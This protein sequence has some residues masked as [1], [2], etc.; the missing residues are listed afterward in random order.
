M[1]MTETR[2]EFADPTICGEDLRGNLKRA[3]S[4]A[5]DH[6]AGCADYHIVSTLK[7]ITGHM[8]FER[9][10][11]PALIDALR[12]I[13]GGMTTTD[14][15]F[16]VVVAACA[17]TGVLSTCAHAAWAAGEG[18][19]ARS[20]FTVLDRCRTPL[21]LCEEYASRNGLT[22]RTEVVDLLETTREFPADLILV[23]NFLPFVPADRHHDLLRRLGSWLKPDGRVVIWQPVL[24]AGDRER[25]HL[26]Q[27]K[28]VGDIVAAIESGTIDI[29]EPKEALV[30]RVE[31]NVMQVGPAMMNMMDPESLKALIGSA[32]FDLRSFD[33]LF[34][35][36]GGAQEGAQ[37]NVTCIVAVAGLPNGAG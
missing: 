15:D 27:K 31:R 25:F 36:L 19:L 18:W 3:I 10:G 14:G 35:R 11:R 34:F 5:P 8:L 4:F 33:E 26:R 20:R 6:C 22:V 37:A 23:H 30:A 9:G 28:Q 16:D 21:M 12:S 29:N 7:R 24:P 2:P 1:S 17:D 32:G 13:F